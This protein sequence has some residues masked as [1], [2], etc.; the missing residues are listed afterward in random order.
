[1]GADSV[2]D[3]TSGEGSDRKSAKH[4]TEAEKSLDSESADKEE[5]PE[6]VPDIFVEDASAPAVD[7]KSKQTEAPNKV[8]AKDEDQPPVL[9][10]KQKV[11]GQVIL[12]NLQS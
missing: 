9:P 5:R 3:L 1:M 10:A 4:K 12:Q 8:E 7:S 11:Y 6:S 2:E